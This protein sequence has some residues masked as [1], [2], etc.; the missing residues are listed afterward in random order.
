MS[1][2]STVHRS[3]S[4]PLRI[5]ADGQFERTEL[6]E[7][8]MCLFRAMVSTSPRAWPHAPWFGL[9]DAFELAP[10]IE[11]QATIAD[12]LNEAL[13]RLGI[14]SARVTRVHSPRGSSHSGDRVFQVTMRLG[15]GQIAHQNLTSSR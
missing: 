10:D 2:A 6:V 13:V 1:A 5:G 14:S 11:D 4:I 12:A 15:D 9:R 8:L 3:L 7:A